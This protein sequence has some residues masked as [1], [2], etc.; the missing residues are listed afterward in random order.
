MHLLRPSYS[1]RFLVFSDL[2]RLVKACLEVSVAT[3]LSFSVGFDSELQIF[4]RIKQ[5]DRGERRS[6]ES[7]CNS[8]ESSV[9]S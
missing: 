9:S 2:Y 1:E 5:L 7:I 6:L 4:L 8:G 3:S